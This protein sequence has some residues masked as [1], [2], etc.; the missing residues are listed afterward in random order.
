MLWRDDCPSIFGSFLCLCLLLLRY[1]V[2]QTVY[3]LLATTYQ[4]INLSNDELVSMS[5]LVC[6]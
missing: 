3:V 4:P 5:L 1:D 6:L 2:C